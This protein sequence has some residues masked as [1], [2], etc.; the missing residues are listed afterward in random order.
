M[1]SKH[2]DARFRQ[3]TSGVPLVVDPLDYPRWELFREITSLT[4]LPSARCHRRSPSIVFW[5]SRG[6]P[7]GL[8]R[9]RGFLPLPAV[10][11][12]SQA[13]ISFVIQPFVCFRGEAPLSRKLVCSALN[14]VVMRVVTCVFG[15]FARS[16]IKTYVPFSLI[17]LGM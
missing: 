4:I 15:V 11:V 2:L 9:K 16:R 3:E 7:Y 14:L 13:Y 12:A 1:A 8:D 5:S 6:L 10:S 17:T